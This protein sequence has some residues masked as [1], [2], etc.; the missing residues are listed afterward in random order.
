MDT[1][2]GII[3]L[4]DKNGRQDKTRQIKRIQFNSAKNTYLITFENSDKVFHYKKENVEII[5]NVIVEDKQTSNVFEYLKNIAYLSDMRNDKGEII[6]VKNYSRIRLVNPDSALAYYLNPNSRKIKRYKNAAPI[7][8]FGCNNSQFKAVTNALENSFSIIQ[9]P[10]GTGKTQTILNIIANLLIQDK[11]VLVVSNNN[12][13]IENV[14]EKLSSLKYNLGFIVAP[15]GKS[16]NISDFLKNQTE[17]YPSGIESWKIEQDERVLLDN[18]VKSFDELKLL[19]DYQEKEADLKHELNEIETEYKHFSK[20]SETFNR[21][22]GK[23]FI[24]L[25]SDKIMNVWQK[26]QFKLDKNGK[27]SN[28]L[29]LKFFIKYKIGSW[30]F[31]R[32][33]E[34]Q[35]LQLCKEL[36]YHNKIKEL[37]NEI[38]KK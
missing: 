30:R 4:T 10:P 19:F 29:K 5:R 9:G 2:H 34:D 3:Y 32:L 13:A 22:T 17:D 38:E 14:Y 16:D 36:Y 20:I 21:V 23:R 31:W 8:P 6:L 18:L 15:L 37:Q 35:I 24:K 7:F 27:L 12:S 11:T 26:L 28:F 1:S 33:E 25:S